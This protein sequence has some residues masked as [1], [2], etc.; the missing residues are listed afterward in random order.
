MV[1][2]SPASQQYL[3]VSDEVRPAFG[4]GGPLGMDDCQGQLSAV[5]SPGELIW[6]GPDRCLGFLANWQALPPHAPCHPPPWE[7]FFQ[8]VTRLPVKVPVFQPQNQGQILRAFGLRPLMNALPRKR[9]CRFLNHKLQFPEA[10]RF[11]FELKSASHFRMRRNFV[12]ATS[13]G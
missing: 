9:I 4:L 8:P 12:S 7:T 1:F 13:H 11:P 3:K 2:S 10:T 6:A 5:F